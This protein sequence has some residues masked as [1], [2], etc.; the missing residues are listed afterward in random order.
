MTE[1]GQNADFRRFTPS[2]GNSSIWRAQIFAENRRFSQKTTGNR[3][4]G[5]VTLGAS[6][7]ARPGGEDRVSLAP[8]DGEELQP[9][10]I[11][12]SL[13]RHSFGRR[14]MEAILKYGSSLWKRAVVYELA[15]DLN[16]QHRVNGVGGGEGQAFPYL[17]LP[18]LTF[19]FEFL[20]FSS[21]RNS[22]FFCA[23]K[24]QASQIDP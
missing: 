23:F 16:Y 12:G 4:L 2:P 18:F 8:S 3:R 15:T 10:E 24:N 21:A 22:F 17:V 14:V 9:G 11:I 20:G 6:P 19:F 7:L 5:S 13:V 1:S